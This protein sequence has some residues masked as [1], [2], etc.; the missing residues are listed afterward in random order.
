M[1]TLEQHSTHLLR[2]INNQCVMSLDILDVNTD[3]GVAKISSCQSFKSE[4]LVSLESDIKFN[5]T[6]SCKDIAKK[7]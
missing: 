4:K 3:S 7:I 1:N 5:Q 6:L 2:D